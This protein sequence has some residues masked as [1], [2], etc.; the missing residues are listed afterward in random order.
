MFTGPRFQWRKTR[1][2]MMVGGTSEADD[3][4]GG[5]GLASQDYGKKALAIPPPSA[6]PAM[7]N[8]SVASK[9]RQRAEE[10]STMRSAVKMSVD[11][12]ANATP[13]I[14]GDPLLAVCSV[15]ICVF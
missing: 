15:A 1:M 8:E 5:E 9:Q 2:L 12:S 14:A 11:A 13:A 4:S 6:I 3:D 10:T 7:T